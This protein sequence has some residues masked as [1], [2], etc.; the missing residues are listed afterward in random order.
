MIEPDDGVCA[1][2]SGG[3]YALA[4]AKALV[5]HAE[6]LDAARIARTSMEIAASICMYTND[7]IVLEEL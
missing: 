3:A 4:A 7:E 6:N 1:I 2:G 5:R